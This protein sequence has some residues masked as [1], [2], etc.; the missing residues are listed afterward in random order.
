MA[1]KISARPSHAVG[2]R[3][4][5]V[6]DVGEALAHVPVEAIGA[7][8]P[9]SVAQH[10][11][12]RDEPETGVSVN[13]CGG[14]AHSLF[15]SRRGL[16]PRVAGDQKQCT[17]KGQDSESSRHVYPPTGYYTHMYAKSDG[18]VAQH[19]PGRQCRRFR[20]KRCGT[21]ESVKPVVTV[22]GY[23]IA[24]CP[25]CRQGNQSPDAAYFCNLSLEV[26]VQP[27]QI[28][29][30]RVLGLCALGRIEQTGHLRTMQNLELGDLRRMKVAGLGNLRP[31]ARRSSAVPRPRCQRPSYASAPWPAP[32]RSWACRR[33][34]SCQC[35]AAERCALL[36][37]ARF[38]RIRD[39]PI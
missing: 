38:D 22:T 10:L 15:H 14:G 3:A 8:R 35:S 31:S 30:V 39:V 4:L 29:A 12:G 11:A 37:T 24:H 27:R 6:G 18:D 20:G 1:P 26:V 13:T 33:C 16:G 28:A 32:R 19:V 36:H 7:R 9:R 21:A 25:K 23:V 17:D 5:E 2:E 34:S